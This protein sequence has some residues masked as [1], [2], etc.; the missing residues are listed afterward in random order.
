MYLMDG[1]LKQY[2]RKGHI[3]GPM[4]LKKYPKFT[5]HQQNI[6]SMAILCHVLF[7]ASEPPKKISRVLIM[8]KKLTKGIII[9]TVRSSLRTERCQY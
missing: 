3:N 6:S 9:L 7:N 5:E 1:I 2:V 8:K 4:L